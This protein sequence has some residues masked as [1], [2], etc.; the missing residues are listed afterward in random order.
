MD[1]PFKRKKFHLITLVFILLIL[2]IPDS[3]L[4][5]EESEIIPLGTESWKL[6]ESHKIYV[7]ELPTEEDPAVFET[8]L[9][10][11]FPT[12]AEPLGN[13]NF[14]PESN[15]IFEISSEPAV[16]TMNISSNISV[17][18]FVSLTT[19]SSAVAS[20][21]PGLAT[22][23]DVDL[24]LGGNSILQDVVSSEG[25]LRHNDI[26]KYSTEIVETNLLI[27]EG[28]S[29]DLVISVSHPCFATRGTLWWGGLETT[30]GIVI[31]GDLLKPNLTVEVDDNRIPHMKFIPYSP[32][33]LDDYDFERFDLFIWGPIDE[34]VHDSNTQDQF[35]EH[36]N[37]P[38]GNTTVEGN[39]TALT[40]VGKI[41]LEPGHHLLKSCIRSIDMNDWDTSSVSKCPDAS[42]MSG[43]SVTF[44]QSSYRFGV[45]DPGDTGI[46]AILVLSIIWFI[47]LIGNIG[48]SLR[49]A[50]I[51]PWPVMIIMLLMT[52]AL[53]PWAAEIENIGDT[54]YRQNGPVPEFD[55][56]THSGDS[57]SLNELLDEK[58]A[59]VLG[60]Y[61]LDSPNSHQQFNE[62]MPLIES[63][64]NIAIAQL[65][66]GN[67]VRAIDLDAHSNVVNG[68]WPLLMDTSNGAIAS[69]LPTGSGDAVLIIDNS[70]TISWSKPGVA[71]KD[72]IIDELEKVGSGGSYND[73]TSL[74]G[75]IIIAGIPSI[76]YALPNQELKN[77]EEIIE[78]ALFPGSIWAGTI[79]GGAIGAS[80]VV[81]PQI[82]FS[83]IG[84]SPGMWWIAEIILSLW[85]IWH[86]ITLVWLQKI[87]ELKFMVDKIYPQLPQIYRQNRGKN[88]TLR[89]VE[90]GLFIAWIA[91][92]IYPMFFIQMVTTP[93][94]TS[95]LGIF[96]GIFTGIVALIF[97]GINVLFSRVFAA[98]LGK[99]SELFGKLS[100]PYISKHV[101]LMMI[102]M[103]ILMSIN[104]ILHMI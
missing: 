72:E 98:S 37:T 84:L 17:D 13:F 41:Q 19:G 53:L 66:T 69:Q 18:L 31:Q 71:G 93:L 76:F 4:A 29:F 36:F 44:I 10:R 28:D 50:G 7:Q 80:I 70:G 9:D 43:V 55:L 86:G 32:W 26:R 101:G 87:P 15:L 39:R 74:L 33:G 78:K 11:T 77:K 20:A 34:D 16:E 95:I 60:V 102:P 94:L 42:K 96:I 21:C 81:L 103:G 23:F 49:G 92:T 97:L 73:I 83:I 62:F 88:S 58:D 82:I 63:S 38:D 79:L 45:D 99:I 40:W 14:G 3:S 89:D 91:W 104:S 52:L 2:I 46:S 57:I 5:Q 65:A 22:S 67:N 56:L 51:M 30:T 8:K 59:L 90:L 48:L 12:S 100:E 47:F 27:N 35:I 64:P 1:E 68:T 54:Y 24:S 75:L 61:Q 85:F 25:A 6:P